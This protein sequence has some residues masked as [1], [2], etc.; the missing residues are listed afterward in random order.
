MMHPAS[1]VKAR[2]KKMSAG[3]DAGSVN[4]GCPAGVTRGGELPS[5]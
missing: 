1:V 2:A 5:G 4:I 3:S